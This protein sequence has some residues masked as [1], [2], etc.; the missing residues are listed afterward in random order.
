MGSA[1]TVREPVGS[2]ERNGDTGKKMVKDGISLL[3]RD[4]N[5]GFY[6]EIETLLSTQH[7]KTFFS[8]MLLP[9][10]TPFPHLFG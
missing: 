2:S 1:E 6:V 10:R 3:K 7:I 9:F 5:S 4:K 8:V